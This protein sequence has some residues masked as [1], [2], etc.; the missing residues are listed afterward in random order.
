MSAFLLKVHRV[1]GII[2]ALKRGS[3]DSEKGIV[4]VIVLSLIVILI[5]MPIAFITYVQENALD[6]LWSTLTGSALDYV[7][8]LIDTNDEGEVEIIID[9]SDIAPMGEENLEKLLDEAKKHIGLRYTWGGSAPP[10]FDCSGYVCFV[11]TTSGVSDMPRTTAQGIYD[12]Y[13]VKI[14]PDEAKAGDIIFFHSTYKTPNHVTHLGVYL[15]NN[16][17]LHAGD[18]I[19]YARTDTA[20]YSSR[21]VGY[22]RIY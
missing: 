5:I 2:T 1:L 12:N 7:E 19:G 4:G 9:Y 15:G 6:I 17:M 21:I 16:Y 11:Y 22:G 20:Y 18:P 3:D 10:Y 14:S 8:G 13:V